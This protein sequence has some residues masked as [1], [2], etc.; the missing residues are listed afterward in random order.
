M[1]SPRRDKAF[2]F[3][4]LFEHAHLSTLITETQHGAVLDAGG[5]LQWISRRGYMV[6]SSVSVS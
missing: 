6:E 2:Y 5:I 1:T 4:T 3:L